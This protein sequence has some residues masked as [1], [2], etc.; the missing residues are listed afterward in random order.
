M[1]EKTS[2]KIKD[3]ELLSQ[4]VYRTIKE[5]IIKD[6][7][8][9]GSQVVEKQL[10]EDFGVSITPVRE[11]FR[12]LASEGFIQI[13]PNK[14]AIIRK[15]SHD[16]IQ[17]SLNVRELLE[18]LAA[19]LATP[20]F[21]ERDFLKMEFHLEKMKEASIK[22]DI[23][24]YLE[25]YSFFQNIILNRCQNDLL[26]QMI[27]NLSELS[28]YYNVRSLEIEGRLANSI[29]EHIQIFNTFRE[30]NSKKA[31]MLSRK[32]LK[33]VLENILTHYK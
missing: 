11:A 14:K 1:Q 9:A 20:N 10:A 18:G 3:Y 12:K 8:P 16:Y 22:K 23:E 7:L 32:H 28:Q 19:R 6:K 29:H 21:E 27:N 5:L 4:K 33:K 2:L 31:E 25:E 15:F 17:N 26:K 30:G 13:F 24:S